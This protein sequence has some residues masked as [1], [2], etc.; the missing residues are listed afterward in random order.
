MALREDRFG[1]RVLRITNLESSIPASPLLELISSLLSSL[2]EPGE[3]A[4]SQPLESSK[5]G[6]VFTLNRQLLMH[7][8]PGIV[9][10]LTAKPDANGQIPDSEFRIVVGDYP[11][12]IFWRQRRQSKVSEIA[13]QQA[14]NCVTQ[15]CDLI[16][17]EDCAAEVSFGPLVIR[18]IVLGYINRRD[19]VTYLPPEYI[20]NNRTHIQ[21]RIVI[22]PSSLPGSGGKVGS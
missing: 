11:T 3:L 7:G 13:Q 6:G 15:L 14:L 22:I 5:R 16:A 4:V 1:M 17:S 10:I 12:K 21:R 19:D 2:S 9:A 20:D 18:D 8:K